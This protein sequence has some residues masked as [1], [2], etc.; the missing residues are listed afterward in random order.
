MTRTLSITKARQDLTNLV[1]NANKRLDEYIITVNGFPAA[2]LMS[3]AEFDSWKETT[4]ILADPLLME[5]IRKGEED[6]KMG[7]V[8]DFEDVLKD[9]KAHVPTQ[10]NRKSKKRA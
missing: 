8:Y 4:E 6:I 3:V 1:E 9:L 7:R 5:A 2:V 10:N